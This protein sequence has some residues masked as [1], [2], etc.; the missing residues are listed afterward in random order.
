VADAAIT[1]WLM[2]TGDLQHGS[3]E[4][5]VSDLEML[6]P[7]NCAIALFHFQPAMYQVQSHDRL[8]TLN[9]VRVLAKAAKL[10]GIS[11]VLS[12]NFREAIR[13]TDRK[14]LVPAA[15]WTEACVLFPTLSSCSRQADMRTRKLGQKDSISP[16]RR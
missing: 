4:N 9:N 16:F 6:S 14:K 5:L 13:A 3:K 15:L 12:I 1:R 7:Q 10:F 11:T 8:T 2:L